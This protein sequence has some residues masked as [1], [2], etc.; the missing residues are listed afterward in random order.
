[1]ASSVGWSS[2][3]RRRGGGKRAYKTLANQD[4]LQAPAE[5]S[6]AE[7]ERLFIKSRQRLRYV[8]DKASLRNAP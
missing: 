8:G 4:G 6:F 3:R 2:S 5:S 7:L 1:M